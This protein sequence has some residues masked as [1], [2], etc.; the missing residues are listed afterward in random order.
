MLASELIFDKVDR[1]FIEKN[2]TKLSRQHRTQL[3]QRKAERTA[4]RVNNK[5]KNYNERYANNYSSSNL[6]INLK[7]TPE[8][9]TKQKTVEKVRK[10]NIVLNSVNKRPEGKKLEKLKETVAPIVR[11]ITGKRPDIAKSINMI[12]KDA[13]NAQRKARG[14]LS[15]NDQIYYDNFL[16]AAVRV[17]AFSL[18]KQAVAKGYDFVKNLLDRGFS[19]SEV[20]L[21]SDNARTM[22]GNNYEYYTNDELSKLGFDLARPL[23][24]SADNLKDT[25]GGKDALK[26]AKALLKL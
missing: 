19:I 20:Y 11:A 22:Q 25:I 1:E 4:E 18:Y 8:E 23:D 13:L 10:L 21:S 3:K 5:I 6:K 12:T 24:F 9:L 16:T 7:L 14:L 15:E 17:G 2:Y 26:R